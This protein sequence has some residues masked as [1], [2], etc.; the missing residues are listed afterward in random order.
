MVYYF[1][2][3]CGEY[4]IYMGKDKYENEELIK[5]GHPEDVWFH[6]DDLSSAHVY[7]RLKPGMTMDDIPDDALL[8]CCALDKANSIAG[9]KKSSVY[10][11][12]TRWKNLRKTPDMVEGQVGYHRPENVRRVK[13][14]KNNTIVRQLEK[15][16]REMFPDLAR[17]QQDRLDEVQAEKK[18]QWRAEEK[19]RRLEEAER[20]REKEER[21]Y[22]R[23]MGQD[24]MTSNSGE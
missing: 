8:D 7:L 15:T 24:K 4:T 23:I 16:R 2:T 19:A 9:C 22:D 20:R 3:R 5:Y 12:Y 1:K 6:V 14:E 18:A 10:V 17:E 13:V 11:I 21:S